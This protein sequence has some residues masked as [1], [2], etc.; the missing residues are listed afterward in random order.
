MLRTL[1]IV[2]LRPVLG[3]ILWSSV[4]RKSLRKS[5]NG[6]RKGLTEVRIAPSLVA[7]HFKYSIPL[8]KTPIS[9]VQRWAFLFMVKNARITHIMSDEVVKSDVAKK[10]E[11]I[12]ALW[13][14]EQTFKKSLKKPSLKGEYVFYDGP[15]F[16]TGTPHYGHLLASTIKDVIP[17]YKTM[18]GYHV[19]RR[20]GW[21]CH[22]LPLEN[23]IEQELNIKTKRDIEEMGVGAFNKAAGNAVLRYA[24]EWKRVIPRLG[25]WVDMEDDYRTMDAT[26]TESVWWAFKSLHDKGLVYEGFKVLQLCPRCGTT[27]S[28]FEVNQGYKDIEDLTATVKFELVDEPGT[29]VLAWTTTPWTLPGN[30]ALAVGKDIAYGVYE[31]EGVK[32]IV[33]DLLA[34][35]LGEGWV[36]AA[37]RSSDTL[38]GKSYRSLFGNTLEVHAPVTEQAKFKNAYKIYAADFVT[39]EDGTGVV[40]IAPAFGEDDLALARTNELPVVHHVDKDGVVAHIVPAIGGKQAKPKGNP[41]ETDGL[42]IAYLTEQGLLFSTAPYKHSYPHCWRCDTPLLNYAASSWFVEVSDFRDKLVAQNKKVDWVP[43]AVGENR[44]GDWLKNARDWAISRARYWGAPIP[45]WKNEVTGALR[46]IGSIADLKQYVKKNGNHYFVM[47]HGEAQSNVQNMLD[48]TDEKKWPLTDKGRELASETGRGLAD[49]GVTVIYTSPFARTLETAHLVAKELGLP[50]S[51]VRVDERLRELNFGTLHNTSHEEFMKLRETLTYTD[52]IGGGESYQDAKSRF[53]SFIYDIEERHN[54]E[55]ILIV[56]HGIGV[57]SLRMI[58]GLEPAALQKVSDIQIPS[59]A[60]VT[61]LPFVPL[62][63]NENYELDLHRPG[64]DEVQLVDTDGSR[65]IRVK[66]VFD[67]WFESGSMPYGQDHY[68]FTK[69]KFNPK[70]GW[71]HKAKGYPADF[72]AEGLDQ[73]RGWFYSLL[74]LGTLLFGKAPYKNVIVNGL[75][76]AEDGRK[77]S[78]KLKNYPDPEHIFEKYGADALR[79]YLLTSPIMRGEDLRFSER[80]VQDIGNKV[81]GRLRNVATFLREYAAAGEAKVEITHVLDRW[82]FARLAQTIAAVTEGLETYELDRA[83]R[84][85]GDFVDDLSTWY[86]R[87]S[88]ARITDD[89]VAAAVLKKALREFSLLL[90]PFAPFAAEELFAQVKLEND[91]ASVHLADWPTVSKKPDEE[92]MKNMA[93]VRALASEALMH[94]QKANSKVRQPLASITVSAKHKNIGTN[95]LSLLTD[96][97]NVKEIAFDETL[98]EKEVKLDFVL[99]PELVKEGDDREMA[100]AVADARKQLGLS[101]RDR[102]EVVRGEEGPYSVELSTGLVRFSLEV[103]G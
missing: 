28:N 72:I 91:V 62:P 94:R 42:M 30:I 20:W 103:K 35:K 86:L 31:K 26:Y 22:G 4:G 58:S 100:R 61:K 11:A 46:V 67:C 65:L 6:V 93:A 57:E 87:R 50:E 68:P 69:E 16:A 18:R 1:P 36:R 66:D 102:A 98:T 83:T 70:S 9:A 81:L 55:R 49:E 53:G 5:P 27:L 38:V 13:E 29:Y 24:H 63:H 79:L 41:K 2:S 95:I 15:P 23:I 25:R 14:K 39:T 89:V 45:V 77:M 88:R 44:F 8:M 101:P 19:R 47:R 34:E 92:L 12:Q 97:V 21:D 75:V 78:K 64:I 59:F 76:L 33:A 80:G 48:A 54:N 71:F 43:A 60:K 99:T 7:E 84:P 56:T 32:V 73:T 51:A 10:E 52:V 3:P 96:E 37:D 90:A 74:V 82:L 40:H 17:R 85:L